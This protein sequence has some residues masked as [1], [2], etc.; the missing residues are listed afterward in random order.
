MLACI[1]K[2]S[3]LPFAR[4]VDLADPR[5]DACDDAVAPQA[6]LRGTITCETCS[7]VAKLRDGP[8]WGPRR[9]AAPAASPSGHGDSREAARGPRGVAVFHGRPDAGGDCPPPRHHPAAH[10]PDPGR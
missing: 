1:C 6:A 2:T 4:A 9:C 7:P 8:D 10:Q 3:V 5:A